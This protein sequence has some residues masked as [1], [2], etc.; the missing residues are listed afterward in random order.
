MA[1]GKGDF[2]GADGAHAVGLNVAK[3]AA[4]GAQQHEKAEKKNAPDISPGHFFV[5]N[6]FHQAGDQQFQSSAKELDEH[7][8]RHIEPIGAQV[9]FQF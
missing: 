4:G 6:G 9:S 1:D 2:A 5:Q 8:Q 7:G 3:Q